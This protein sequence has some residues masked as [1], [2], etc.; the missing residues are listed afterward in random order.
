MAPATRSIRIVFSAF[1]GALA[2]FIVWLTFGMAMFLYYA[3]HVPSADDMGGVSEA[4]PREGTLAALVIVGG[5]AGG[6]FGSRSGRQRRPHG[7]TT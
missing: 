4:L 2:G 6:Y 7:D 1:F 5:L 3:N